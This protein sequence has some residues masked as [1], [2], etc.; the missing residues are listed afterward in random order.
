MSM[1]KQNFYYNI[2]VNMQEGTFDVNMSNVPIQAIDFLAAV[3]KDVFRIFLLRLL[4]GVREKDQV[5]SIVKYFKSRG[6]VVSESFL[7]EILD[8]YTLLK[9]SGILHKESDPLDCS[10]ILCD[11][12]GEQEDRVDEGESENPVVD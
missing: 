9:K 12:E 4:S 2:S 3:K 7:S 5:I 10:K 6:Q 11:V 1:E 8:V